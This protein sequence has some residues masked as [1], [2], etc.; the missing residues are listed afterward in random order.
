M[1]SLC[2]WFVRLEAFYSGRELQLLTGSFLLDHHKKVLHKKM[3]NS[4]LQLK[5]R[6]LPRHLNRGL[7]RKEP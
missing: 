7:H 1:N 4:K 5:R 2:G 3:L 6:F